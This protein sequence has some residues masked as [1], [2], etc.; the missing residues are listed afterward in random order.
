MRNT[1]PLVRLRTLAAVALAAAVLAACG[2]GG[3][4]DT[5]GAAPLA[6]DTGVAPACT[7]CG[8]LNAG[9]Y[10]G[11]GVGV[12][13]KTNTTDADLAV[14]VAIAG[15]NGQTVTLVVTNET[16][17]PSVQ[18]S[19]QTGFGSQALASRLADEQAAARARIAEFNRT[20]WA[21]RAKPAQT[22][23][24]ALALKMASPNAVRYNVG[25]T[26]TFYHEL[27]GTNRTA[28]LQKQVQTNDGLQ[29]N[30]WVEQTELAPGRVTS[31]HADRLASEFVKTGGV[32]DLLKSA[33]G[34][35]WGPHGYGNLIA[36]TGQPL[37]IVVLNFNGD[38]AAFG[39]VGYFWAMH[40]FVRQAE[41]RNSNES[42]SLYLDS[43][44]MYLG[45]TAG[46]NAVLTALAH[47]GLHMSNFYRRA[48]LKG[49]NYAFETWLEEMTAMMMEDAAASQI[50]PGYNPT[51]DV[52]LRDFLR[53]AS[54]DCKLKDF[55][56]N[57]GACDGYAL[58]G[59]FGG[60]LLRQLGVEFFRG[61]LAQ[62]NAD[63]ERALD[64][65]IAAA[66]S[67][68]GLAQQW[69]RFMAST[70]GLMPAASAPAGF[71][72]PAL[73]EGEFT[74][75]GIDLGASSWSA[76]ESR[77]APSQ[78]YGANVQTHR[79]VQGSFSET[80]SLPPGAALSVVIR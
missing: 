56:S 49:A 79:S 41:T 17:A 51:R 67:G 61:L 42:L 2:G 38:R 35:L 54:Y 63:S 40:L 8:A 45:G 47:E 4:G 18:T 26:R 20:G 57:A 3:G 75:T 33:G 27:D 29:V 15:L 9:T 19:V 73:A 48:V 34:P 65:A 80:V 1:S 23:D 55:K 22:A 74:A 58:G 25:A 59:S 78:S 60:F 7:N 12:W 44:T 11:T 5:A 16:S 77:T 53:L 36:G 52:R 64:A 69:R 21:A 10:A 50:D 70:L 62:S 76:S 31:A 71:G 30:V 43:E 13:E 72:F 37:D 32:Y 66:R 28:A 68:S 24:G 46:L 14:P 6:Q 39:T